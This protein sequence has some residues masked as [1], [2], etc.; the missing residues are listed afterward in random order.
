MLT[1]W[2]TYLKITQV[3]SIARRYFVNNFYDGML[4]ILGSLL[5]FFTYILTGTPTVESHIIMLAGIGTSV[6]MFISGF[7]GS[8]LS[9]KAEQQKIKNE[10]E[11]AMGNFRAEISEAESQSEEEAIKKA[12]LN[13]FVVKKLR[14]SRKK[15]PNRPKK[16]KKVKTLYEKA[17]SFAN[18]IVSLVNGG[19]PLLGGLVPLIPFVFVRDAGLLTFIGSFL[20]ITVFIIFL[21]VFLGYIS[22]GSI[23]KNV[24]QMLLA[25]IITF[26][27]TMPILLFT[28]NGNS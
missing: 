9:E 13:D 20:I 16:K 2:K 21:G 24:L 8:Y 15:R 11:R 5:G 28:P 14:T 12:M 3:S 4:T 23:I 1:K 7:S 22:K 25:F 19:A 26:L 17:E 27:V 6:S 10:M 18:K